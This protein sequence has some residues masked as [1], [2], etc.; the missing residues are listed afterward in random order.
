MNIF[1][2]QPCHRLKTKNSDVILSSVT[3][4]ID[5][6]FYWF[7]WVLW[8]PVHGW[9][10]KGFYTTPT[11]PSA[12]KNLIKFKSYL[13]EH[14]ALND[15]TNVIKIN[16]HIINMWMYLIVIN[17]SNEAKVKFVI[18]VSSIKLSIH[19]ITSRLG[20]TGIFRLI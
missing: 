6:F 19:T 18:T 15:S 13:D 17:W 14:F 1:N 7:L 2:L 10:L 8:D 16:I 12:F 3:F 5:V 4:V 11:W 9:G 20:D